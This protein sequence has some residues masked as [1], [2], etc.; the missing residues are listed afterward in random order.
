MKQQKTDD[1]V[2]PVIG[3]MLMLVVTLVIAAVIAA[4]AG[5]FGGDMGAASNVVLSVDSIEI[6]DSTLT[7]MTFMHKGGDPLYMS[8]LTLVLSYDGDSYSI[9][10]MDSASVPGMTDWYS[11]YRT[12]A[13]GQKCTF[14]ISDLDAFSEDATTFTWTMTDV[15]GKAI[16]KGTV[17]L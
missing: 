15:S 10:G 16:A 2:S 9:R 1:A 8:D 17:E 4:F 6:D 3:V 13:P 12:W 7:S 14:E 5:G 11:E